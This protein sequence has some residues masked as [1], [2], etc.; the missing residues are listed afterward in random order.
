MDHDEVDELEES[1]SR[2]GLDDS[3]DTWVCWSAGTEHCE[4]RCV[5]RGIIGKAAER[6]PVV[7]DSDDT[8]GI[9]F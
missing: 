5:W 4:F 3:G 1:I 6:A 9:P 7:A 2:C 8:E